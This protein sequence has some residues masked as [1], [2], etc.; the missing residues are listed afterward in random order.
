MAPAGG[1][2]GR[3]GP[4]LAAFAADVGAGP[5]ERV[6]LVL[7]NAGWHTSPRLTV[8]EGLHLVFLPP[9]TPEL[10]PAERLWPLLNAALANRDHADLT[11]LEDA[12]ATR[13]RQLC[14]QPAVTQGATQY[15]WWPDT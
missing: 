10:Q 5:T 6:V 7:D 2:H 11:A 12:I 1:R 15:H 9:Y 4:V 13:C 3:A 14:A 8:P